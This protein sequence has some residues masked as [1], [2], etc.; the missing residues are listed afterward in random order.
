VAKLEQSTS[1]VVRAATSFHHDKRS[2]AGGKPFEK[3]C[4]LEQQA[5]DATGLHIDPVQLKHLF[6]DVDGDDG[7]FHDGLQFDDDDEVTTLAL[8]RP[9]GCRTRREAPIPS[10]KQA[11]ALHDLMP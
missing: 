8:P 7:T 11:R 9:G 1:P 3:L 2:S 5:L 4:T 6:G 10:A